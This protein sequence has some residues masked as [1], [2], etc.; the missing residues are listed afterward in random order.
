MSP[1][2]LFHLPRNFLGLNSLPL[3]LG[4]PACYLPKN[5]S[6]HSPLALKQL[7]VK[8]PR[9]PLV[10]SV[11]CLII[12]N[13]SLSSQELDIL[14]ELESRNCMSTVPPMKSIMRRQRNASASPPPPP[15]IGMPPQK[16]RALLLRPINYSGRHGFTIP[17]KLEYHPVA[18]PPHLQQTIDERYNYIR[19]ETV[20]RLVAAHQP[21]DT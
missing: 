11:L 10:H 9:F 20:R 16:L 7:R 17:K 15:P 2:D 21:I 14:T 19:G 3:G 5:N 8:S 12:L 6:M 1:W 18:L 4:P 13:V